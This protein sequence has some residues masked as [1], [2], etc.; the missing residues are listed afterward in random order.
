MSPTLLD[1]IFACP[2]KP[3]CED[4]GL[5]TLSEGFGGDIWPGCPE[6]LTEKIMQFHATAGNFNDLLM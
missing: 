2:E 5:V 4:S 1:S 6:K 3:E